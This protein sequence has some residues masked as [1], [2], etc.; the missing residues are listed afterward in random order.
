MRSAVF[1]LC[2]ALLLA[3][4][5]GAQEFY[6]LK[7]HGGPI[8]GIATGADGTIL[9]ASF[10]NSVGLWQDRRPR[11][12]EGHEA[13]VNAVVYLG[14]GRAVSGGDDFK[15]RLWEA[16]GSPQVIGSHTAKIIR[17]AVNADGSK[18]AAASWDRTASVHDLIGRTAPMV[19]SGHANIVNDI[20]FSG[21]GMR[22]YTAS[23]DG[24]II[25]WDAATGAELQR[26]EQHGFGL[27]TLVLAPDESWLAYGAVDGVTRVIALPGGETLHDFTAGRRPVLAMAHHTA[28]GRIAVGDA[29][30]YIMMIDTGEWRIADDF[31][32]TLSGP[33]WALAFAPDGTNIHAGGLDNALYSWPV[34]ALDR[35]NRMVD[36]GRSF[37]RDPAEMS[38]GERQFQRKC[39]I[40]HALGPDGERRA[41][42][43]LHGVFGRP[44]GSVPGYLYSGTL[45]DA[46]LV[47]SEKT[48]DAL[49]DVGPDHYVP[50]S[51][52]PQQRITAPQDRNDLV[53]F[54]KRATEPA[55]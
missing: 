47:W 19:L 24:A 28:T 34:N 6:T 49:F 52:M 48:I 46:D 33:I 11:W 25:R 42:P 51:K 37:L 30:G 15:L 16:D 36:S 31:R 21:D 32:A 45:R 38:N 14:A 29:E 18:V 20:A 2:G 50:G 35:E 26:Y 27:N 39:S 40:C 43:S 3:T 41:G 22:L 10:D 17:L 1:A 54:L 55:D 8:K 7:G 23:A 5:P 12:L 13:A 4:A 9:T 53:A 44:A